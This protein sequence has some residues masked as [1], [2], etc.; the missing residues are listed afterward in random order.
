MWILN[1]NTYKPDRIRI[2]THCTSVTVLYLGSKAGV[3]FFNDVPD[4]LLVF[5]KL[6]RPKILLVILRKFG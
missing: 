4:H 2:P 6:P 1:G 3:R 5:G